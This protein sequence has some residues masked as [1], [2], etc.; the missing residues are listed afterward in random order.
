M[1]IHGSDEFSQ[2]EHQGWQRVASEYDGSWSV[3][4]RLYIPHLLGAVGIKRGER[5]LDVACGP[6][7]VAESSRAIGAEPVGLDFSGE[8]IRIA[9]ERVSGIQFIKGDAQALP[10]EDNSFDVVVINFGILHLSD[11]ERALSESVRVLRDKGR[12]GFTVWCPPEE[13]PGAKL[14]F[15][16]IQ[17]HADLS[18]EI[19]EGPDRYMFSDPEK[20]K[21]TLIKAGFDPLTFV[22]RKITEEWRIPYPSFLFECELN[23]G[24][25]TSAL[26]AAQSQRTLDII[27]A[28][29]DEKIVSHASDGVYAIPYTAHVVSVKKPDV[30]RCD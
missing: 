29:L 19:P 13:S 10:F 15:E 20:C 8:M 3:L 5:V 17:S 7:Y 18:V 14:V 12:F 26:L 1:I 24:V 16:A 27:R 21:K 22:S 2:F 4:S 25:R 6:G 30:N 9:K 28:E 11:P 23:K